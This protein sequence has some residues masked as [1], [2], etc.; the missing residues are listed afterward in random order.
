MYEM[1]NICEIDIL[2]CEK[3][4]SNKESDS[5]FELDEKSFLPPEDPRVYISGIKDVYRGD[6]FA[7][8]AEYFWE[9]YG[10]EIYD[11]LDSY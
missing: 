4:D 7:E 9:A 3:D 2:E 11:D 1:K 10:N 5:I 6:T 8:Y